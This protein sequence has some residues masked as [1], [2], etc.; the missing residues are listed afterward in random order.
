[1]R[2]LISA[3]MAGR[4]PGVRPESWG[5]EPASLPPQDGVRGHDHQGLPPPGPDFRE[6]DPPEAIGR[7]QP[8]P[9]RGSSVNSELLAQ[10]QVL[11]GELT[12]AP[13]EDGQETEQM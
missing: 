11:Q 9:R 2:A 3:L 6:A 5:P 8:W 12:V 13:A 10:G 7:A 4:P 1:M